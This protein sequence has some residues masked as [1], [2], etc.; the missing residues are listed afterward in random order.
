MA[1]LRQTQT[2]LTVCP[3]SNLKLA[4]VDTLA[5]HN[6]L[7]LLNE[8]L[9][10]TVNSDDPSYFGGDLNENFMALYEQ[11]DMSAE[12]CVQLVKNSFVASFLPDDAKHH[13]LQQVD[14]CSK[15]NVAA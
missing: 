10:V 12:Q 13:W 1:Y 11:L 4:V 2:P 7:A 15:K 5:Q 9:C 3:M 8:G 6:V 14:I